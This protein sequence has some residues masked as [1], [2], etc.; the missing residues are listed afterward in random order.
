MSLRP[1]DSE[2][3]AIIGSCFNPSEWTEGS[4]GLRYGGLETIISNQEKILKLLT[5]KKEIE[6]VL[7][8]VNLSS[9]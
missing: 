8:E 4:L 6:P 3:K 1:S 9:I 5:S 2:T 7:D